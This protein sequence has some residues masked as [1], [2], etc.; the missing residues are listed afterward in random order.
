MVENRPTCL[1]KMTETRSFDRTDSVIGP[2]SWF[3]ASSVAFY[4]RFGCCS[5]Q[6]GFCEDIA[7]LIEDVTRIRSGFAQTS[8]TADVPLS[9]PRYIQTVGPQKYTELV[10]LLIF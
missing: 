8:L 5:D 6:P 7:M 1:K 10:W 3:N 2:E 9:I 4:Q